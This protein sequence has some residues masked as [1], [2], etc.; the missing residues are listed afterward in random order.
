MKV[1]RAT[2][3]TTNVVEISSRILDRRIR[4]PVPPVHMRYAPLRAEKG[5]GRV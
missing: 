2:Q 5:S 4:T 3:D 1:Q